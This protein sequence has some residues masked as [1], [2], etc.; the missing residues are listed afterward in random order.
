MV[1]YSVDVGK[2]PRIHTAPRKMKISITAPAGSEFDAGVTIDAIATG[3]DA[4]RM[5]TDGIEFDR[6]F[7]GDV[8][9]LIRDY[10]API[11]G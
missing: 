2:L 5:E 4:W 1:C 8:F 7:T 6:Y 10:C 11:A 3:P 9:D